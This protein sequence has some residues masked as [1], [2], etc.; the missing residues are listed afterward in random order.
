MQDFHTYASE[1]KYAQNEENTCVL[2][3]LYS[4]LFSENEHVK[5]HSVFHDFHNLYHVIQLVI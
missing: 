4:D 5:K 1:I 3:T 2:S